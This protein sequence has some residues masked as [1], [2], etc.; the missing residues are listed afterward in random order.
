VAQPLA[1]RIRPK[2]FDEVVGQKRIVGE[3]GVLRKIVESGNIPNM[4]FY[5]PSGTGKTTVANIIASLT[6]KALYRVNATNAGSQDIKDV[7]AQIGTLHAQNGILLYL[8]EIQYFS[9]KQ[10]QLLLEYIESGDITLIASTTENP[11]FYIY[12]ALLSR[13]SVFEFQEISY[14]DMVK[15][16][17]RAIKIKGEE[18]ETKLDVES[19]LEKRIAQL[20]GGDCR[21]AINMVE[22][23]FNISAHYK[24][25]Y[26]LRIADLES[27]GQHS[28]M[29][30]DRDGDEHY[31]ILSAFHKSVRGSDPNAAIFYLAKLIAAD[32][33]IS[34]CRRLLAIASED[35]G[36]AYPMAVSIVKACV[37]SAMQLGYPE[38]RLPLAEATIFLAT[39]PKSNSACMA[40][41][42]ALEDVKQGKGVQIPTHLLDAH[43]AGS[44]ELGHGTNY[45]YPHDYP[46]H[47]IYQQYLPSDIKTKN[48]YQYQDNKIELAT[49]KYWEEIKNSKK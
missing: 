38:A 47:Y 10:Q 43:Y 39:C 15:A 37:D 23:L 20:S 12:N 33:L 42:A 17:S 14:T 13:S 19:G 31:D 28:A 27:L 18:L 8:D 21:K 24:Q 3:N 36:L 2:T 32:D 35:I 46:N 6:N 5:G 48:Y 4:I 29:K 1:D 49:K 41:D 7:I 34:P 30:Y 9:K 22:L 45:I 44:K 26:F 25:T 40:I 11:Y 16:I